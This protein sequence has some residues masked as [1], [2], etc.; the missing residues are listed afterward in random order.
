[1]PTDKM[2]QGPDCRRLRTQELFSRRVCQRYSG[3]QLRLR[4]CSSGL[5]PQA[6]EAPAGYT[7]KTIIRDIG[8]GTGIPTAIDVLIAA[9]AIHWKLELTNLAG[10]PLA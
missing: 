7:P 9:G 5:D 10:A 8:G 3:R 1:M 6:I 4:P 2:T